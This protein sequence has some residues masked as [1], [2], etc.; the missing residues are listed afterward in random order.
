M[1][2]TSPVKSNKTNK[3]SE[4][5][6]DLEV[7]VFDILRGWWAIVICALIA[8]M[9]TYIFVTE[10]YTPTYYAN[11]TL[12][13]SS[14][15]TAN[16]TVYSN[17]REANRL[18]DSFSYVLGSQV[19]KEKIA[20]VLG[21]DEFDG[22]VSTN[23]IEQTN[24]IEVSVTASSP[25]TAFAEVT[26]LI[27]HHNIVT[28]K[29][30][31]GAVLNV[32]QMP[33]VP[34][35][36]KTA[37]NRWD[38]VLQAAGLAALGAIA[39][40]AFISIVSDTVM[41]ENDLVYK[42]DCKPLTT[43]YHERKNLSFRARLQGAKCSM[44]ITNPTT[45]FRFAETY[46]L[47]RTRLE[48]IT[49][50]NGD[51]VIMVASVLE[52]EGKS[53]T[54]AN[55]ALMLALNGKKVLLM[56]ADMLKP[57]QYKLFGTRVRRGAG[58]NEVVMSKTYDMGG[59]AKQ[60]GLPTLSLLLCRDSV[61]NSTEILGSGEMSSFIKAAKAY[62]D[63]VIIDT[64]PIAYSTDAECVA[65]QADA[66]ILVIRQGVASAHRINNCLDAIKQSGTN[67]LGC[68]FNNVRTFDLF[69]TATSGARYDS[70]F[71]QSGGNKKRKES[72]YGYG[73]SSGGSG[74]GYGYGKQSGYGYGYGGERSIPA[75]T[76]IEETEV[77]DDDE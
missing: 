47:F 58:I 5:R 60:E 43:I 12:V 38:S 44:L 71:R 7:V 41:T 15:D 40:L 57:A 50:K 34:T 52:N 28:D 29:A 6:I 3:K 64:P 59:I 18:A 10:R 54:A 27:E 4:N 53:T 61:P 13:V 70:N 55:I 65:E 74:Y 76:P 31:Q 62:F 24:L 67:V 2:D 1:A 8:A 22:T 16:G 9:A 63:Y 33:T 73:G 68:V 11:A 56:D 25:Q 45:S 48:Y 72:G 35:A 49:K 26:A 23:L 39:M 19:M 66:T 37:M 75:I 30:M 36:P 46:R 69:G 20:E 17:L 77:E 42:V 32:L 51:K 14:K 21:M